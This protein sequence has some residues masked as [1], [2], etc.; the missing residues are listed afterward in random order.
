MHCKGGIEYFRFFVG[1]VQ[2]I[3]NFGTSLIPRLSACVPYQEPG[4]QT[5]DNQD[6]VQC[7]CV[8]VCM[9]EVKCEGQWQCVLT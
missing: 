5:N 3:V 9:L 7:V 8:C 6:M 1:E 2:H 4:Y